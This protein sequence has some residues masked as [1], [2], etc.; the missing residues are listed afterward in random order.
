MKVMVRDGKRL[1]HEGREY[2]GGQ[3]VDVGE[4]PYRVKWLQDVGTADPV[5]SK[6]ARADN[7]VNNNG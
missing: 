3:V 6:S 7:E 1:E 5:T 2:T 4:D